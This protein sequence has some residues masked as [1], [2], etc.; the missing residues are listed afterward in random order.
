MGLHGLWYGLTV[1]LVYVSAVGV[2]MGLTTDWDREVQ[3]VQMRLEA[4]K[5]NEEERD[6]V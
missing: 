6:G 1:A 4:D 5:A 2:W 3:K